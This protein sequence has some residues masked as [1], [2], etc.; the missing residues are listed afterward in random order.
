MAACQSTLDP[1]RLAAL[2]RALGAWYRREHRRLPWRAAPR[3]LGDPYHV[4]VSEAMLQQTQVAT[5]VDYFERFIERLPTLRDLAGADEQLVLNLWQGLGYYRRARHLHAAA[6]AIVAQHGGEVPADLAELLK[7]P[8][9]GRYTAGAIASIAHGKAA[10]ILDGNVARVLARLEAI[11]EPVDQVATRKRLWA[12]AEHYVPAQHPGDFNQALMELGAVVCTPKRPK[13]L[14]CSV[15]RWCAANERGLVDKLPASNG[16]AK[17]RAV[18]H[19][20]VAI[21]KRGRYLFEQRGDGG[22]WAGMWQ[23]TTDEGAG[24]AAQGAERLSQ[25]TGL[26]LGEPDALGRFVHVTTHKRITFEVAV[27]SVVGGRLKR[28]VGR[29]RKLDELDDLPLSK[30]QQRAVKLVRGAGARARV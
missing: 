4:L 23:L 7:L 2:R 22:L 25:R 27:A 9:V 15:R 10:P 20:V 28:G 13:C 30:A 16:R 18:T 26:K 8:G 14:T 11:T 3:Q 24:H 6:K 1:R 19:R 29:W 17:P 5:V 21:E 12:L